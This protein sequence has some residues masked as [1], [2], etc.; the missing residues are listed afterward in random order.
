M[1]LVREENL[2]FHEGTSD[3]VYHVELCETGADQYVVNF[4]YGRRGGALKE[5]TKTVFPVNRDTAE[6][7]FNALMAEKTK[8]GYQSQ[9][10]IP[11]AA[12]AEHHRSQAD[13]A[14]TTHDAI[15]TA[16]STLLEAALNRITAERSQPVSPL[17]KVLARVGVAPG[18]KTPQTKERWPL[19]RIFWRVGELKLTEVTPVLLQFGLQG[20]HFQ[21]YA[22]VWA[23]GRCATPEYADEIADVLSACIQ[24]KKQPPDV[25]RL[26]IHALCRVHEYAPQDALFQTLFDSLPPSLQ[27]WVRHAELDGL[28]AQLREFLFTVQTTS[29]DYLTTLYHLSWL[30]PQTRQAL[31]TVVPEIPLKPN[32]FRPLRQLFKLAEFR[33]DVDMY[34][35][36]TYRLE[37]TAAFYRETYGMYVAVAG[38]RNDYVRIK[39]EKTVENPRIAYSERTRHYLLRRVIRQLR[40]YGE[41]GSPQFVELATEMLLRFSDA[42]NHLEPFTHEKRTYDYRNRRYIDESTYH[43]SDA[44]Y[45]VVNYLLYANSPRYAYKKGAKAWSCIPPYKPGNPAPDAREEAFP[46]LWTQAPL[47]LLRLLLES[48]FARVQEFAAKAFKSVE[49]YATLL[50]V[51]QIILLLGLPYPATNALAMEIA[52]QRYNSQQPDLSLVRALLTCAYEPARDLARSWIDARPAAFLADTVFTGDVLLCPHA[53]VRQ[54]ARVVVPTYQF[55]KEQELAIIS[56]VLATLLSLPADQLQ[57]E[58]VRDVGETLLLAFPRRIYELGLDVVRDL[59]AHPN[60]EMQVLGGKI[61]LKH[62]VEAKHLPDE[63]LLTLLQATT[64]QVRAIGVQ[65]FGQLPEY[66]LLSKEQVIASFCLSAFPEIR[67][68]V[69]PII[70]R[71]TLTHQEFGDRLAQQLYPAILFKESS[72]GLHQ[73]LYQLFIGELSGSLRL[74]D[75]SKTR[76]LLKSEYPAANQLGGHLL[77]A[78]LDVST[79]PLPEIV[80]LG[81]SELLELR[82]TAWNVFRAAP[83][84]IKR[85]KADALAL[86]DSDWED[87]RQFA[88]E[89]FR[90]N[91]GDNDWSPEL[92]I[93][94]CDSVRPDV[95]AFGRDMLTRFFNETYGQEYLLKLSQH[96]VAEIQLLATNY[97]ERF[98]SGQP[99]RI[100]QLESYF[101]TVLSQVN[102]AR[103]A[104]DRIFKFLCAEA[105]RAEASAQVAARIFTR[106][107]V[108]MAIGDKA[109]CIEFLR[110]I[111]RQYPQIATPLTVLDAPIYQ[112]RSPHAI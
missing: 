94:L 50:T 83:E 108:T 10:V 57:D 79:F 56:R 34:T 3:K 91:F 112:K 38:G 25:R 1:K 97:L 52:R 95:Q 19:S 99:E 33:E 26:A 110:D 47:H 105:L 101:V 84:R 23:L 28:I 61:L 58:Y 37:T 86:V 80:E 24:N 40:E 100:A 88:F 54:W 107:S 69:K 12:A 78:V 111:R 53:D 70:G 49:N 74:F 66:L 42:K 48:R 59:L 16:I 72:E 89:Y 109:A 18:K 11:I 64:P 93:A 81:R 7:L 2:W 82:E 106:Q 13:S 27:T 71:L 90:S 45:F 87:T 17:S 8:K 68:A 46:E 36:L 62:T 60:A 65:L 67:Q 9:N 102:K 39:T 96:P 43:D 41:R 4:K 51:E 6:K 15:V 98:A 32:Y 14:E 5:G 77:R 22:L 75:H 63:I 92:L 85:E 55:F 29:N 35:L 103:V 21:D 44:K 30:Y 20:Q 31:L 76:K 73:D 104:K